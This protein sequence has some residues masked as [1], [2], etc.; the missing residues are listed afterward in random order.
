MSNYQIKIKIN[1]YFPK[2]DAIPF[3]NY[4]CVITC[5]NMHSKIKLTE[6]KYQY[7]Q[8]IF[9]LQ[10]NMDLLFNIKIINYLE[11]NT[12]IGIYDLILPYTKVNQT[13]QRKTSYYQQQVKLIMNSNVKIKLFGTMMNI[14]SIYLDLIFEISYLG[15]YYTSSFPDKINKLRIYDI[16]GNNSVDNIIEKN[17]NKKMINH[18]KNNINNIVNTN[19][20]NKYTSM[21]K[22]N[23]SKSPDYNYSNDFLYDIYNNELNEQKQYII[24]NNK[25]NNYN[26]N[27]MNNNQNHL[28]INYNVM[29][30]NYLNYF[31]IDNNN[32][33]LNYKLNNNRTPM[34]HSK[35]FT[36]SNKIEIFNNRIIPEKEVKNYIKINNSKIREKRNDNLSYNQK[37]INT[38]RKENRNEDNIY[39]NNDIIKNYTEIKKSFDMDIN[40]DMDIM[41]KEKKKIELNKCKKNLKFQNIYNK[42]NKNNKNTL[43]NFSYQ[44]QP[45]LYNKSNNIDKIYTNKLVKKIPNYIKK[46]QNNNNKEMTK[47]KKNNTESIKNLVEQNLIKKPQRINDINNKTSIIT[48]NYNNTKEC[49]TELDIKENN[50]NRNIKNKDLNKVNHHNQSLQN[51]KYKNIKK[52]FIKNKERKENNNENN[53]VKNINNID[54]EDSKDIILNKTN[55]LSDNNNNTE[56]INNNEK[57]LA[58]CTQDDIKDTIIKYIN[59]YIKYNKDIKDQINKNRKLFKKLLLCKEKYYTELKKNNLL[60]NK[61][62]IKNIKYL[63][64]VNI[65]SKLNENLYFNMKD[66]KMKEFQV[67]EKIFYEHKNSPENKAKEAK[68]KIQEKLEQQKKIHSLLKIVRE[69]IQKYENLSQLYNDDEKKKILFKSLLVRYGVREK[70]ENKENNLMDKFKEIQKKLEMEKNNNLIKIKNKEIQNDLYK[71]VIKEEDDEERSSRSGSILKRGYSLKKRLS[72]ASEDSVFKEKDIIDSNKT[73]NNDDINNSIVSSV[74][75]TIKENN[76]EDALKE[77]D[78]NNNIEEKKDNVNIN[79]NKD[80]Q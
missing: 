44:N 39:L 23:I 76:E 9:K 32:Y 59:D 62:N 25:F 42:M 52:Y 11:N 45:D 7:F 48:S 70:E 47:I 38:E 30:N 58:I 41:R 61:N 71:N 78:N 4:I 1:D 49:D 24:K 55:I 74:L 29:N 69:L 43:N 68:R 10:K 57:I 6:Y 13:L 21:K 19:I 33:T 60:N 31:K 3:D 28:D 67:F 22:I 77:K 2:I 20:N 27:K 8:N 26:N 12:L 54:I 75:K 40:M 80:V 16:I 64:H 5:N 79:I 15:N 73:P 17:Y 72:W 56:S 50:N 53:D 37:V 36:K 34:H 18:K 51:S 46:E 65:R 14:T 63:I 66:V 35:D